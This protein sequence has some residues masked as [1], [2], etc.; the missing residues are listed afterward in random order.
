MAR[1]M[2]ASGEFFWNTGLLVWRLS[3]LQQAY[4]DFL[5][6]IADSF[7]NLTLNTSHSTLEEIYSQCEAISVD[8]GIM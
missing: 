3:V 8:H 1:Q 4:Q 2:I 6:A 5:P 7:L